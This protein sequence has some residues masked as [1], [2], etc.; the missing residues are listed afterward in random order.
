MRYMNYIVILLLAGCATPV[1]LS[2]QGKAVRLISSGTA[3]IEKCNH[4]GLV[5]MWS[6]VLAGGMMAAQVG[7]RNRVAEKGGNALVVSS[8]RESSQGHAEII[9]DAYTCQ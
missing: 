3:S 2:E 8:Q 9:G 7:I 4:V 1:Q 5:N 6:P